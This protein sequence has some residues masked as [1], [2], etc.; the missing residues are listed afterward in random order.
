MTRPGT[1]P[2][3]LGPV[4]RHVGETTATVWVQTGAAATVE[5]LGATTRT[6]EVAGH[7]YAVVPVTGLEPDSRIPY[8]VR[9]DGAVVWPVPHSPFPASVIPTR[10]PRTA[11][12]ARVVFG[13]CRYV[14]L[15]DPKSAAAY[16]IDALDA[17][18]ARMAGLPPEE[19]PTALL[20][21]GDQVYADELTPQTRRRIAG[22]R[23]RPESWPD[24][25]IVGYDEYVGLYRDS[26]VDPEIRWILSTVPT[27]MIF[28]DHDVR[29]DWNTSAAWR[30]EID[31]TPWWRDRIRSALGSYWVYQHLGNLPPDELAAD[32]DWQRV[33]A[34]DGDVWPLL[35]ELAD[36]ADA[37]V[38]GAKG[39]RFSFRWDMGRT[40]LVMIDSRNGRILDEGRHLMLG[41]SEFAWVEEQVG[42][43][44]DVDHLLLGTSVPWLLAPALGDVETINEVAAARPGLRG[45]VGEWIR[46]QADMEHWPAFRESFDRL[47]ALVSR[48]ATSGPATV[49]VLSGDV[50]HSYAARVDLPGAAVHQLVCSPVHNQVPAAI[51]VAFRL[52]WSRAATAATRAWVRHDG[53]PEPAMSWTKL[54]GPLFGNLIATL[55]VADRRAEVVFEKPRSASTLAAQAR[56]PL[57]A[58]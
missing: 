9:V 7:H 49:S 41:D 30:E 8:E 29:D 17:Y 15:A 44:G 39:V 12:R 34:A 38:D 6:F 19:W 1:A 25:E 28:D 22:R 21:L 16:G 57:E 54:G 42:A 56:Y 2:L 45:R 23:E 36:R 35:V 58:L 32:P 46:Q 43:P 5:I 31:R 48:A 37:E 14:K 40:R 4:L 11:G 27:A 50:H 20:L 55:D 33:R 53:V 26:W 24:D 10:G 13:S 47:G 52:A 18:A 51:R 3:V